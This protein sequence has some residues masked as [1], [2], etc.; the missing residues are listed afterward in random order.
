MTVQHMD[1]AFRP[2][3]NT[4]LKLPTVSN[5]IWQVVR[6]LPTGNPDNVTVTY[7]LD[8]VG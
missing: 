7:Y 4:Q 5:R 8:P 2:G 3:L 1:P 6:L